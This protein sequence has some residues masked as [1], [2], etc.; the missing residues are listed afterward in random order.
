MLFSRQP[1]YVLLQ[2]LYHNEGKNQRGAAREEKVARERTD[3]GAGEQTRPVDLSETRESTVIDRTSGTGE[4]TTKRAIDRSISVGGRSS[5]GVR[6]EAGKKTG[7]RRSGVKD[8][9]KR[10]DEWSIVGRDGSGRRTVERTT[11]GLE[12]GRKVGDRSRTRKDSVG[13]NVKN[14]QDGGKD[15]M[16]RNRVTGDPGGDQKTGTRERRSREVV[17]EQTGARL[18]HLVVVLHHQCK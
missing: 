1:L 9:E 5:G 18:M 17:K 11:S 16:T 6:S 10:S 13:Q 15:D 3:G 14:K 4:Q 8:A 2:F 12:A 7:D